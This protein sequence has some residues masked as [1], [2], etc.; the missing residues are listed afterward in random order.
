MRVRRP[1]ALP[2][3]GASGE[4]PAGGVADEAHEASP[5]PSSCFVLYVRSTS[6]DVAALMEAAACARMVRDNGFDVD[7]WVRIRDGAGAERIYELG[8]ADTVYAARRIRLAAI[9]TAKQDELLP[10]QWGDRRYLACGRCASCTAELV[11]GRD[12]LLVAGMRPSVRAQLRDAGITTVDRL[13]AADSS[14]TGVAVQTFFDAATAGRTA[15]APRA[16]RAPGLR[17]HRCGRLR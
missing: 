14:V 1:A 13:A 2:D 16:H 8:P 11:A 12:L 10:V 17:R 6:S 5:I 4:A 9:L 15:V 7:P 3:I